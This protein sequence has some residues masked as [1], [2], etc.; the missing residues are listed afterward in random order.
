MDYQENDLPVVLQEGDSVRLGDGTTV[1]FDESGGAR[2]VMIGDE[3]T[4][5]CTLFPTMDYE[6][7]AG[8]GSY[9]LTAGG[10]DLKVEKI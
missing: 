7:A 6:L 3:F 8:S 10:M 4:A 2:D 9:R 1:R 5:R